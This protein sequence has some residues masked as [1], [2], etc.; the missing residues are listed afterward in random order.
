M[1]QYLNSFL[2][3]NNYSKN[4]ILSEYQLCTLFFLIMQ[5]YHALIFTGT[6]AVHSIFNSLLSFI[7]ILIIIYDIGFNT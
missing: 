7:N 2:K 3:S 6:E 4:S 1:N 5:Y